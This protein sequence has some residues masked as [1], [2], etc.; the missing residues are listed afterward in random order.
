MSFILN[1]LRKSEQQRVEAQTETLEN[2]LQVVADDSQHKKP[3]LAIVFLVV[4][5][6]IFLTYFAWTFIQPDEAETFI[7]ESSKHTPLAMEKVVIKKKIINNHADIVEKQNIA[8]IEI[9]KK[10]SI[11]ERMASDSPIS[12]EVKPP[13]MTKVIPAMPE[14]IIESPIELIKPTTKAPPPIAI[15]KQ[16]TKMEN[17][18]NE[19]PYLSELDYGFRRTVPAVDVNVY[20][21]SENEQERFI[22]LGMKKY[23]AGEVMESGI[24][25]K[26]ILMDSLLL[27]YNQRIFK[28]ARK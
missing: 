2:K 25:L 5:N 24:V 8:A 26:A 4:I 22:M 19:T 1:A 7:E 6:I 11:A 23:R 28:L 17:K 13:V 10:V 14:K 16:T 9:P 15:V 3:T 18:S 21:Y 27:E 20:V 12:N